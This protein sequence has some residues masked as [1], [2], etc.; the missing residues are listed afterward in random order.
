[1]KSS[2]EIIT[3]EDFDK[4][5]KNYGY[6]DFVKKVLRKCVNK[7]T[8]GLTGKITLFDAEPSK[9]IYLKN[10]NNE[11]FIVRYFIQDE[12]DKMWNASYTLYKNVDNEDGSSH[13]EEIS[14]GC[15]HTNYINETNVV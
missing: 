8:L 4:E 11:E 10:E 5:F 1:M 15:S 9:R 2:Y 7:K 12:I 6:V 3:T 13:G 14:H